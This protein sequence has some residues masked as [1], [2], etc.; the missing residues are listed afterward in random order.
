MISKN[1]TNASLNTAVDDYS[2]FN[3]NQKNILKALL[4]LSINN[5]VIVSIKD[6][7]KLT[8]VTNTTISSALSFLEKNNIIEQITRRGVIFTGCKINQLK[9]DDIM[10]RYQTKKTILE[11]S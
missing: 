3:K 7:N 4:Q 6:L 10:V 11:K 5:D 2:L 9:I 1:N 8:G